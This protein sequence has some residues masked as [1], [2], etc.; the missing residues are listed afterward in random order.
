MSLDHGYQLKR[1]HKTCD[2]EGTTGVNERHITGVNHFYFTP[3][4]QLASACNE[5]ASL[6]RE[7][8]FAR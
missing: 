2:W 7:Q 5:T 4:I 3:A 6:T 1:Q 8:L